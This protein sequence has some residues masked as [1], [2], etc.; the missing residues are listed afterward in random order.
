M[1]NTNEI[2]ILGKMVCSS[3]KTHEK[4]EVYD[5]GGILGCI[6]A[7]TYKDPPKVLIGVN[8]VEK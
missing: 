2:N 7:T 8:N 5:I 1:I 6:P 4:Q 3:G